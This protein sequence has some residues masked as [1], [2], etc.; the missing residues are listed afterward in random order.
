[1]GDHCHSGDESSVGTRGI[2]FLLVML[3][4]VV[5]GFDL[6]S[7]NFAGP[8]IAADFGIDRSRL[9]PLLSASL[10]GIL[11][12]STLV[13]PLG[14]RFGRKRIVV[15]A[16]AAFGLLSLLA[17]NAASIEQLVGLRFLIGI[18]LGAVMPNGL[19]LA[20]EMFSQRRHASMI[21]LAGIGITMGG[22]MAGVAAARLLPVYGWRGL[23]VAGGILPLVIA[24]VVALLLKEPAAAQQ[25]RV[26][27][28]GGHR[29]GSVAAILSPALRSTTITIWLIF[30]GV[31]LNV[32]LLSS[33][34]PLLMKESGLST[35]GAAWVTA[36]FHMG[37]VLGGVCA[38]L[39]LARGGWRTVAAFAAGAAVTM[40]ILALINTTAAGSIALIVVAGFCMTGTQNA[41]NGSAGGAYPIQHR[42][43]GLGWALGIGR[44]G[45][46]IGPLVG[47]LAAV[48]DWDRDHRFYAIPVIPLVLVVLLAMRQSCRQS[49]VSMSA[50]NELQP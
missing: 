17:A 48:L 20:G 38:S 5:E 46:I 35:A 13:A 37:G 12:G 2:G 10:V 29:R 25:L 22:V 50:T 19:A 28:E 15:S 40:A 39:A 1:V 34:I 32:H 42:A 31:L 33:W 43:T 30:V 7:A 8:S 11:V 44:L 3:A 26:G 27:S 47:A 24:A 6:Q 9:G 23:F 36:A 21:A 41:I 14:D 18:G 45:S 16:S 4:L 49:H